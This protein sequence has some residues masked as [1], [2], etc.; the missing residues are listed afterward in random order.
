MRRIAT[1]IK[2]NRNESTNEPYLRIWPF[3]FGRGGAPAAARWRSRPTHA[4][5]LRPATGAGRAARTSAGKRGIAEEGLARYVCGRGQSC[6]QH[7]AI[8]KGAGRWR[9]RAS[10]YRDGAEARLSL[11]RQGEEGRG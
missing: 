11:C 5:S 6:L 3:P 7:L 8:A 2:R 4:Q 9:E 1:V 10:L